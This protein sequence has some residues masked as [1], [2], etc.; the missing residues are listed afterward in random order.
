MSGRTSRDPVGAERKAQSLAIAKL[1]ELRQARLEK[2]TLVPFT[3]QT[4]CSSSCHE[5]GLDGSEAVTCKTSEPA[6]HVGSSCGQRRPQGSV[7]RTD[8]E[9]TDAS[10]EFRRLRKGVKTHDDC[11]KDRRA[12]ESDSSSLDAIAASQ[13]SQRSLQSSRHGGDECTM[14]KLF[15]SFGSLSLDN[16]GAQKAAPPSK[17]LQTDLPRF[18]GQEA[19]ESTLQTDL[20]L[21]GKQHLFSLPGSVASSLYD[22]QVGLMTKLSWLLVVDAT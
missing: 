14:S 16:G 17:A 3:D 7:L 11:G 9:G 6:S 21:Q 22:H 13:T 12:E 19:K 8:T 2:A 20:N 10:V 5:V 18:N 1:A 4:N 15:D